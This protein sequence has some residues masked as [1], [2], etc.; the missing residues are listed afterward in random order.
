[1][2]KG[3]R[4]RPKF[5]AKKLR[6]IRTRFGVSQN[7]ML[8]FLALDGEFSRAE[9][10]AYERGVREPPLRVLLKYS[11]VALIWVNVLIDDELDLPHRFPATEMQTGRQRTRRQ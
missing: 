8:K 1:M 7:E 9:L 2:G 5:L 3:R 10:S 4:A 6:E 11:K